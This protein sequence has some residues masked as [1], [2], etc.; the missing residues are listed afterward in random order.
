M[1]LPL[2]CLNSSML[3]CK[4]VTGRDE[5]TKNLLKDWKECLKFITVLDV[6]V[7][8]QKYTKV[9]FSVTIEILLLP[10]SRNQNSIS[11]INFRLCDE[12]FACYF[13][14][15]LRGTWCHTGR[16]TESPI[17]LETPS[18]LGFMMRQGLI[19]SFGT[20]CK[21]G[22]QDSDLESVGFCLG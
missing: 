17:S 12:H 1:T 6:D 10:N 21:D 4:S 15:H 3:L 7:S 13:E 18:P 19:L 22:D 2:L 11:L 9:W 14:N 20:S 16:K 5:F 8:F